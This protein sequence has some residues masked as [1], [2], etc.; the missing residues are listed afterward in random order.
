[1]SECIWIQDPQDGISVS[2]QV[3]ERSR[4]GYPGKPLVHDEASPRVFAAMEE[5]QEPL[6]LLKGE[7]LQ[8]VRDV[9]HVLQLIGRFTLCFGPIS[10]ALSTI[11]A[12]FLTMSPIQVHRWQPLLRGFRREAPLLSHRA[13]A[14]GGEAEQ[15]Q[16]CM[17]RT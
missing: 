12:P 8:K 9:H 3:C 1:M 4:R 15:G 6:A 10:T 7:D 5:L 17:H 14:A 2:F 13:K 16:L 11:Y